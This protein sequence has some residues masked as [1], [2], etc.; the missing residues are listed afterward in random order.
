[1]SYSQFL[2]HNNIAIN[3]CKIKWI[4]FGSHSL[5]GGRF[6]VNYSSDPTNNFLLHLYYEIFECGLLHRPKFFQQKLFFAFWIKIWKYR[7]LMTFRRCWRQ[8]V[9]SCSKFFQPGCSFRT[10]LNLTT[11]QQPCFTITEERTRYWL[12]RSLIWTNPPK[13]VP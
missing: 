1:M 7:F 5:Y 6:C 9:N 11:I 10:P 2:S 12:G 4:S 13:F 8:N 3:A